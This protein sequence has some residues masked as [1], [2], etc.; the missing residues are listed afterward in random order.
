MSVFVPV[1]Q[2]NSMVLLC[3]NHPACASGIKGLNMDLAL[4]EPLI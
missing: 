3:H 1:K 2:V 4:Y